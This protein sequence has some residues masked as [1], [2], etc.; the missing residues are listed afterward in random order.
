MHQE[1]ETKLLELDSDATYLYLLGTLNADV[2]MIQQ[3]T[4]GQY[5]GTQNDDHCEADSS[6]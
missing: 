5:D 6:N 3:Y 1:R 4:S 2:S